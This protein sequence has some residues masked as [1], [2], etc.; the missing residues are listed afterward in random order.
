MKLFE[1]MKR[2]YLKKQSNGGFTLVE[3]IVVI[4]ILAILAGI[5]VPAYSGYVEKANK[6]A[7]MQLVRDIEQALELAAYSNTIEEGTSGYVVLTTTD[8]DVKGDGLDVAMK[9]AFGE[10]YSDTL[11]LA[12]DNW[13]SNGLYNNLTPEV[14]KAVKE[15]SYMNGNRKDD[16]LKDVETLT[17]MANNLVVIL[18]ESE[19]LGETTLSNM[20]G[21]SVL[22]ETASKYG[23]TLKEGQ[24]WD[25]W[26]EENSTAYGNLLVMTAAD[27]AEKYMTT[28]GQED[29]Y[30]MSSASQLILQFSSLY[31]YAARDEEFS[32]TL[33]S[34]MGHLNGTGNIAGLPPVTNA[35]TG[36]Q[37]Y[38]SLVAQAGEEYKEYLG[39]GSVEGG[40][41]V[42]DQIGFLSVLSGIGNPSKEQAANI[43]TDLRNENL[44]TE[45]VVNG[46]Y[47]DYLSGVDAMYGLYDENEDYGDWTMGIGS[48]SV[49]IMVNYKDGRV[50][51]L[52]SLPTT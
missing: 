26:G 38:N 12:Y 7:D 19:N 8:V 39:T 44:F 52:N 10:F 27:E 51:V 11:K 42:K 15:S 17:G 36:A 41:A 18:G 40:Q 43:A 25:E 50:V 37:W 20:F 46:M 4:A 49:A 34:Y 2:F 5:A 24:T 9:A 32:A 14:A 30:Q 35:T 22:N 31:A 29:E 28:M 33:D 6:Q 16:L 3:L 1:K 48:G 45:G 13:S 47:N 21:E 23:I